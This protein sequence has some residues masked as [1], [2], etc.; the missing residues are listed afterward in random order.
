MDSSILKALKAHMD[1]MMQKNETTVQQIIIRIRHQQIRTWSHYGLNITT[2]FKPSRSNI[3]R[4]S[5][6]FAN[7]YNMTELFKG[8]SSTHRHNFN[9]RLSHI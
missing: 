2:R 8:L 1:S 4:K 7:K 5:K 3:V 6:P 9:M